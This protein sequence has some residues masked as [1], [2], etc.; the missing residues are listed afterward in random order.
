MSKYKELY[1]F[2]MAG[3]KRD[4]HHCHIIKRYGKDSR[5]LWHTDNKTGFVNNDCL[6]TVMDWDKVYGEA[7]QEQHKLNMARIYW[8]EKKREDDIALLK[9]VIRDIWA[10]LYTEK[11]KQ[12][13]ADRFRLEYC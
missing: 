9:D 12:E 8:T 1:I 6:M 5:V 13:E 3:H 10:K 2:S 7:L 4:C 11:L